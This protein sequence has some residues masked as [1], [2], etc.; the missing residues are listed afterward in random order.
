MKKDI[1]KTASRAVHKFGFKCKKHSPELLL[2]LWCLF[3]S[4]RQG[5]INLSSPQN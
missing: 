2:I 4:G 3:R 1:I 5:G